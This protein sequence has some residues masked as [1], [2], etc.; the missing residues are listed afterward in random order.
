MSITSIFAPAI[1]RRIGT[2]NALTVGLIATVLANLGFG[3]TPDFC[4]QPLDDTGLS[5]TPTAAG[6]GR[7]CLE[8]TFWSLY[9]AN[10]LVGATAETACIIIISS[11]FQPILGAVMA[12]VNTAST[13][14][15]FVGSFIGGLLYDAGPD[16]DVAMKFRLPFFTTSILVALLLP[17][18]YTMPTEYLSSEEATPAPMRS[19]ISTSIVLGLSAILLSA[20]IIGTLDTNLPYRLQAPPFWLTM[21]ELAAVTSLSSGAYL[22]IM[23]PVGWAVGKA[24]ASSRRLKM[25]TGVGFLVLATAFALLGPLM[26]WEQLNATPFV[27]TAMLLRAAGS[28]VSSNF[29]Y[30]DLVFGIPSDEVNLHATISTLW[31]AAYAVGW[32]IGP[33]AGGLLYSL[34]NRQSL[35]TILQKSACEEPGSGDPPACSCEW[36]PD[37]GFV[38]F[39]NVT[40][41]VCGAFAA[42]TLLAAALNIHDE[43]SQVPKPNAPELA[44]QVGH[45]QGEAGS[46][47]VPQ[48]QGGHSLS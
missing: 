22:F 17:L 19:V 3:L 34:F 33:Y 41:A 30:P 7:S 29:V 5:A 39:T 40:V 48:R 15:C 14:G 25:A 23:F 26:S 16:D 44:D 46:S 13:C 36:S 18:R 21:T 10:G 35:C 9:F 12:H 31:N 47:R 1:I 8:Y 20:A 43:S 27:V 38:G 24:S 11:R 42:I 2:R 32:A 45:D 4:S 28:A 6:A 37:N